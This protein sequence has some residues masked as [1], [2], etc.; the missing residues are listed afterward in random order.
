MV[1]FFILPCGSNCLEVFLGFIAQYWMA[2]EFE[3]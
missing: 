2:L 3:W 1:F